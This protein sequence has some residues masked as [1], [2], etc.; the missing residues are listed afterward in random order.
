MKVISE[1]A[2]KSFLINNQNVIAISAKIKEI[3]SHK[4][5]FFSHFHMEIN[6]IIKHI[7]AVL[8]VAQVPAHQLLKY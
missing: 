1:I 4:V 3:L 7:K 2:I 8:K 6:N 5:I